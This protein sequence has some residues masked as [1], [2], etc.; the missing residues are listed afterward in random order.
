M[1]VKICSRVK[2]VI[3]PDGTALTLSDLPDADTARWAIRRQAEVVAAVRGGLLT[4]EDACDR[5]RLTVGEFL[6][7]QRSIDR[8]GLAGFGTTRFQDMGRGPEATAEPVPLITD[9]A[10]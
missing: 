1:S 3:G 4:L 5:Y 7:W 6:L 8:Y 10:L 2:Y 9:Y